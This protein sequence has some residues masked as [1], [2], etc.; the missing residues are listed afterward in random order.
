VVVDVPAGQ[1]VMLT[2]GSN[3]YL[4]VRNLPND[5]K[6]GGSVKLTFTFIY[7]G[8]AG[9]TTAEH[10]VIPVATPLTALLVPSTGRT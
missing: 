8:A 6:V 4:A 2:P 5:L 9:G 3:R 1:L 7:A 10:V